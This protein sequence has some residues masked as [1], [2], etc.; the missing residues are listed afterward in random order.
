MVLHESDA[1]WL[2]PTTDHEVKKK[3]DRFEN[4]GMALLET[5]ILQSIDYGKSLPSHEREEYAKA[6]AELNNTFQNRRNRHAAIRLLTLF[7]PKK[8]VSQ[9]ENDDVVLQI[10]KLR[11]PKKLVSDGIDKPNQLS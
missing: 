2:T 5:T 1:G 9:K 8:F 10:M 3:G 6:L 4:H 11:R 7:V